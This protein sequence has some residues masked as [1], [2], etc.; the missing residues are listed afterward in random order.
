M[1][2]IKNIFKYEPKIAKTLKEYEQ[3]K[4]GLPF[5]EEEDK[6]FCSTDDVQV[7]INGHRYNLS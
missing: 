1:L 6:F 3:N 2:K 5:D 4:T 7:I